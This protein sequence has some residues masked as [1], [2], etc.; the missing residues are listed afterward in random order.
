MCDTLA[1]R[2]LR[3]NRARTRIRWS[4]IHDSVLATP[5]LSLRLLSCSHTHFRKTLETLEANVWNLID[6]FTHRRLSTTTVFVSL[7][8]EERSEH[9]RQSSAAHRQDS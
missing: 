8:N 9:S 4:V 7:L 3:W 1:S 5:T 6:C 2:P